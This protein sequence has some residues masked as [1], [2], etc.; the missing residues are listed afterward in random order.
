MMFSKPAWP[1]TPVHASSLPEL[2][3][4]QV[5]RIDLSPPLKETDSL[6]ELSDIAAFVMGET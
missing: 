3:I 6:M 1:N 5:P 2:V 4:A